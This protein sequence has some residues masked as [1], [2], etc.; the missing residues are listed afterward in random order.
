MVTSLRSSVETVLADAGRAF[1]TFVGLLWGCLLAGL[2]GARA[3]ALS[4]YDLVVPPEFGWVALF[5]VAALGTTW[6]EGG[7]YERFGADPDGGATL[8]WL[9]I[10]F[11]P[12]AFLPTRLAF[13][14][15][16]G[17]QALDY[18]FALATTLCSGWLAFYGGLERLGLA[19][20]DFLRVVVY[21][22]AL[23]AIPVG[24]VVLFD[25]TWLTDDLV[26][27]AVAAGVQ[28][29]ACWLGFTKDVP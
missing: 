3:V 18:L 29:A 23:G 19:P 5:V 10:F 24:A 9:A 6:L 12:L 11:V 8:A 28:L 16:T 15:L 22:V 14:F 13:G 17:L 1:G 2:V 26:A 4:S 25:A 21:A 27:A 7:G 20:D